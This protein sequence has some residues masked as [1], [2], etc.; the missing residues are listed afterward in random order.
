MVYG[1]KKVVLIMFK[2]ALQLDV[3]NVRSQ[4]MSKKAKSI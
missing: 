1:Y 4:Q 2:F 3:K